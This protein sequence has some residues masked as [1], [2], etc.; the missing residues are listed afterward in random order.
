MRRHRVPFRLPVLLPTVL[1]ACIAAGSA[2]AQEA[3][4]TGQKVYVPVYSAIG[5]VSQQTFDVAVT[6]SFRNLD[7]ATPITIT[8]S[9]YYDTAGKQIADLLEGPRTLA[10]FGSTQILI[11]QADFSGDVGANV[12][13]EW[14]AEKPVAPPLLEAVMVGSRGTQAFAFTSRGIVLE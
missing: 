13:V 5:F 2:W 7:A 8:S 6:L 9:A 3:R 11:K 4:S 1:A 12:V 14:S 10:P